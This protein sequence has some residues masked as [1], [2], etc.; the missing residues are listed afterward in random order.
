MVEAEQHHLSTIE[1]WATQVPY[2]V[3]L[4]EVSLISAMVLLS[5]IGDITRASHR[6]A[7]RSEMHY[8]IRALVYGS[9]ILSLS[10]G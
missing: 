3:Q 7:A 1:Q 6:S 2:L 9:T 4:P 5:A 8:T 10:S